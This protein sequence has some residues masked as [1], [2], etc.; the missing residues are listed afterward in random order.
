MLKI[1]LSLLTFAAASPALASETK[2]VL[3]EIASDIDRT[4]EWHREQCDF[5]RE[6]VAAAPGGGFRAECR[7]TT[8]KELE[9][10]TE[11]KNP[12]S[13]SRYTYEFALTENM[14]RQWHFHVANSSRKDENEFGRLEWL[15]DSEKLAETEEAIQKLFFNVLAYDAEKDSLKRF[16]LEL[17][18]K[19]SGK[20]KFE[21]G[22]FFDLKTNREISDGEAY[23]VYLQEGPRHRNYLRAGLELTVLLGMGVAWYYQNVDLN[24]I[25]WDWTGGFAESMKTR[26]TSFDAV[27]FDNNPNAINRK[28]ILPVGTS[29]Y[30]VA[31]A[32]NF[33]ALESL[34]LSF[35]ASSLWEYFVEYSEVVSIND[36]IMTPMGGFVLGETMHQLARLFRSKGRQGGNILHTIAGAIL[37]PATAF[38][39]FLDR[40]SRK[41]GNPSAYD[42]DPH[43]WSRVNVYLMTAA[44]KGRGGNTGTTEGSHT[45]WGADAEIVNVPLYDQ[46]GKESGRILYDTTFS[47]LLIRNTSDDHAIDEFLLMA[48]TSLFLAYHRK[49]LEK[50][51]HGRLYGYSITFGPTSTLQ[52][53]HAKEKSTAKYQE[54]NTSVGVFG[55]TV[56][57][58][59]YV[60]GVR[61]RAVFDVHGDFAMLRSYAFQKNKDS[62]D[63]TGVVSELV[64]EGHYYGVG[65]SGSAELSVEYKRLEFGGRVSRQSLYGIESRSRYYETEDKRLNPHDAINR[66]EIF[67]RMRI[68]KNSAI[69]CGIEA[70]GR[71][72]QIDGFASESMVETKK[73]CSLM[74]EF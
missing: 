7:S 23:D 64:N 68:T 13:L 31:R 50:D 69:K 38:H 24:K 17:G 72:S 3:I 27:R 1:W 4:K 66:G 8:P 9:A 18:A 65:Y 46:A 37:D 14:F 74:L 49:D 43:I 36:Q 40:N 71:N 44:T 56:D 41:K 67:V 30:M 59:G 16:W 29:Y 53:E 57:I 55:N 39:Q 15:V 28:H 35:T 54:L 11:A 33:T 45:Y 21:N 70:R 22:K 6:V 19:E 62:M 51:E 60:R 63:T 32:N 48:K 10:K 25:D 34:L 26:F 42:F 61:V 12:P 47:K 20:I 52:M 73:Y 2:T 5:L 58:T